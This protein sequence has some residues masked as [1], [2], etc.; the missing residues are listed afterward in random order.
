MKE[1]EAA[2]AQVFRKKGKASM[3]EKDFVFAV[4]L[5]L[6]WM[7]P[8]EAQRLLEIGLQSELLVMEGGLVKPTFDYRMLDIPRGYA[9][10]PDILQKGAQPKGLLMKMVDVISAKTSLPAQEIISRVNSTQDR[11]G[12]DVEVAALIV[13][14]SLGA[15]LS[16]YMD[17]LEEE[18]GKRY[19][20]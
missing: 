15:D 10:A 12:V 16:G 1:L 14:G 18:I 7:T 2:I 6:R 4:S 8:K 3:S 17:T 19:K 13:A 5:D 9:P 20:R 11:M